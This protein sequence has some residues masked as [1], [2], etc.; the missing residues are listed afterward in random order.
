MAEPIEDKGQLTDKLEADRREMTV[1]VGELRQNYNVRRWFS[2]S[3]QRY[4]WGWMLGAIFS[5]FFL[6]HLP[7]RNKKIYVRMPAEDPSARNSG[8]ASFRGK[9]AL[10]AVLRDEGYLD[11]DKKGFSV[12]LK[13]WSIIKPLLAAYLAREIYKRVGR[14]RFGLVT[15]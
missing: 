10:K 8:R 14:S 6:S 9:K 3:V 4:P 5:G 1:Q 2:A 12:I 15:R 13:F 7:A 11:Q